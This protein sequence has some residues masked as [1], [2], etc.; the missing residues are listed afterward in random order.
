M[1]VHYVEDLAPLVS[2]R[3]FQWMIILMLKA[4]SGVQPVMYT[5]GAKGGTTVT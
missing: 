5:G 2:I 3:S 1:I 4:A